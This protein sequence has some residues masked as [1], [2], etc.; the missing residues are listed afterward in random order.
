MY[1]KTCRRNSFKS[2]NVVIYLRHR[3]I[4]EF[5]LAS[6]CTAAN[7]K[8]RLESSKQKLLKAFSFTFFQVCGIFLIFLW[9]L[10]DQLFIQMK[11]IKRLGLKT[12]SSTNL[13]Q[14]RNNV[15]YHHNNN[16][17]GYHNDTIRSVKSLSA[18]VQLGRRGLDQKAI[19]RLRLIEANG[20]G[21]QKYQTQR[22]KLI[23]TDGPLKIL[24]VE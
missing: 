16:G 17:P 7:S 24:R 19:Q 5:F 8:E 6:I 2:R 12:V 3:Y 20:K 23:F 9:I 13:S 10:F 22:Y 1:F 11:T 18:S 15:V 14:L 21:V 4:Q